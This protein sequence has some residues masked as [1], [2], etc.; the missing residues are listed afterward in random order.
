MGHTVM[1]RRGG[2]DVRYRREVMLVV[3]L[4]GDFE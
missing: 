4:G 2:F 3:A 1:S